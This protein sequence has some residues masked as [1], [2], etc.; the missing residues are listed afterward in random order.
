[1]TAD[2]QSVR[3]REGG[4]GSRWRPRCSEARRGRARFASLPCSWTTK[5]KPTAS[6][7]SKAKHKIATVGLALAAVNP[8][9]QGACVLSLTF[10]QYPKQSGKCSKNSP[11]ARCESSADPTDSTWFGAASKKQQQRVQVICINIDLCMHVR[12]LILS[13]LARTRCSMVYGVAMRIGRETREA[14]QEGRACATSQ[15]ARGFCE[16][17]DCCR[18]CFVSH[19]LSESHKIHA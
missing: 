6:R 11:Y 8:C 15:G 4:R 7:P 14:R 5:R 9:T 12:N 19:R 2:A 3:Q 16:T 18:T 17:T 13:R 1:M 10:I